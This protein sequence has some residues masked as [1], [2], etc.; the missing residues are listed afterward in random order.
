M[1]VEKI[2]CNGCGAPLEVATTTQFATCRH[3]GAKLSIQ[4]TDTA[5]FTEILEQLTAKTDQL[6]EQVSNLTSYTELAVLDR[7]WELE[8]ENYMVTS[9]HGAKSIPSEAGSIGGG[10]V[11]TLFGCFWTVMAFGVTSM[12]PSFGPFSIAQVAFPLF[13][14]I[15]VIVGIASSIS[16]FS[17]AGGYRRAQQRYHRRRAEIQR[18]PT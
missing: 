13:G 16:S 6:S 8:R 5:T 18:P 12:A 3:C 2:A 10:I 1:Q 17:K 9:K 14:V 15:F 4:R 11:I 7:E